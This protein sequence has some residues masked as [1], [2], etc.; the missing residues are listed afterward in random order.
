MRTPNQALANT[1]SIRGL[2]NVDGGTDTCV[3][4]AL[5]PDRTVAAC[6]L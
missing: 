5:L 3:K 2:S 1:I 4:N 6:T